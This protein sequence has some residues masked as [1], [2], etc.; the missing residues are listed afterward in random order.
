MSDPKRFR[1]RAEELFRLAEDMKDPACRRIMLR[2][3]ADYE[4]LALKHEHDLP[5]P[6]S[7][8]VRKPG[9]KN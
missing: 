1:D 4:F 5:R 8:L 9:E 6:P 7:P 2:M 3:V